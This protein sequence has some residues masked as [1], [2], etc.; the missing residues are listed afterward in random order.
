MSYNYN[1]DQHEWKVNS[2][3]NI[4]FPSKKE[5]IDEAEKWAA[6]NQFFLFKASSDKKRV[7]LKCVK[8]G[9]YSNTR[10]SDEFIRKSSTIKT[11]CPFLVKGREQSNGEWKLIITNNT[12]NHLPFQNLSA[13][14]QGRKLYEDQIQSVLKLNSALVKPNQ[15][16]NLI[17]LQKCTNRDIYNVIAADKRK[18]LDGKTPI[19]YLLEHLSSSDIFSRPMYDDTGHLKHLFFAFPESIKLTR[20]FGD[21]ILADS[22]YKTNKFKLPLLHFVGITNIGTSFS[23]GYC[24]LN[25]ENDDAYNWALES[26]KI[27]FNLINVPVFVTDQENALINAIYNNYPTASHLLCIWHINKNIIKNCKKNFEDT[28]KFEEFMK[29]WNILLSCTEEHQFE[30]SL[31]E[32]KISYKGFP[33]AIEYIMKNLYPVRQKIVRCWTNS[34]RHLGTLSTSRVEGQHHSAIKKY[35]VNSSGDLLQ[36]FNAF[37]LASEI[38]MN[39]YEISVSVEKEKNF[40]HLGLTC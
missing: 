33:K 21:V 20:R 8:G 37:R 16:I 13:H 1:N 28:E 30:T 6:N 35:L 15:I 25:A 5:L 14:P 7:V 3:P 36:C 39:Q 11:N 31:L 38:Q 19:Q 10:N 34:V 2:S 26:F 40:T 9:V 4:L 17:G 22:T 18:K 23:C 27:C 32:F 29:D 24:F 12:H